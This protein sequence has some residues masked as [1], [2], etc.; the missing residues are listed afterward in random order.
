LRAADGG[1]VI[2]E[3]LER[4]DDSVAALFSILLESAPQVRVICTTQVPFAT[5]E[6][7]VPRDLLTRLAGY[8]CELPPLRE[9]I[10]DLGVLIS[11]LLDGQAATPSIE[12]SAA[13]ALLRYDWPGNLRELAL[14]VEA[15]SIVAAQGTIRVG[16]LPAQL[17]GEAEAGP[18]SAE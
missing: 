1:T 7:R 3:S 9:R 13:L 14:V 10:A 17:R 15:A 18:S 5:L 8:R 11:A 16:H 6:A 4:V 12:P 2:I